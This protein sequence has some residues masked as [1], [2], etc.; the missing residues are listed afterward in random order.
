MTDRPLYVYGLLPARAPF[1]ASNDG[2]GIAGGVVTR[3]TADDLAAVVSAA[4]VP[5]VVRTRRNLLAHTSVLERALRQATVLP[6]RF[7]TVAP[8]ADALTACM[9]ANRTAFRAALQEIDGRVEVGL[10][11]S[12]RGG[13]VYNDIVDRDPA[14]RQ[15]R[16]R[17]RS[18]PAGETYY[19][20]IEL[21]RR[22][23]AALAQQRQAEAS[24]II[25]DLLPLADRD[26]ELRLHDDNMILNRAFLVRRAAESSFDEAVERAAERFGDR[27]EFRYVGP[28]PPF[29]FVTLQAGWLTTPGF[30]AAAS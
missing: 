21:G 8:S 30:A 26:A 25:A 6:L 23:E 5:H 12:W 28:V 9:A 11:A 10:K 7:G 3:I 29:N 2:E 19:E 16:D 18:R 20:R 17:L 27:L 4:E 24:A 14:L 22:V 15:L 13:L 1:A